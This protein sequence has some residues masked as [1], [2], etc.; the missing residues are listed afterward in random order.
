MIHKKN[1]NSEEWLH[2]LRRERQG[3]TGPAIVSVMDL[4]LKVGARYMG[5][6]YSL[7]IT[8]YPF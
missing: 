2:P 7:V 1:T 6:H 4:L 8:I 3:N 5:V